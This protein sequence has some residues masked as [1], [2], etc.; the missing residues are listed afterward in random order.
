M[1]LK[2]DIKSVDYMMTQPAKLLKRV[3]ESRRPMIITQNGEAKAVVLD[4]ESY[5]A[6]RSAVS[7]LQLAAQGERDLQDGRFLP[8][9]QALE[10][11]RS[12]AGSTA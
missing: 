6:L 8:Q 9:E 11:I 1:R 7:L 2:E 4:I 10:R 3:S 12:R 5:E